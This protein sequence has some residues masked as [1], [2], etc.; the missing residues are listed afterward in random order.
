MTMS[1]SSSSTMTPPVKGSAHD[2]SPGG[3]TV[4]GHKK[5]MDNMVTSS[6]MDSYGSMGDTTTTAETLTLTTSMGNATTTAQSTW[7]PASSMGETTTTAQTTWTPAASVDYSTTTAQTTWIPATSMGDSTT[8]A[9][10]TWTPAASIDYSTASQTTW[11]S[12]AS[13]DGMTTTAQTTWTPAT[14]WSAMNT[15]STPEYGSGSYGGGAV[16]SGYQSCMQGE[17]FT[18]LSLCLRLTPLLSVCCV[19]WCSYDGIL[20]VVF[21]SRHINCSGWFWWYDTHCY[22]RSYAGHL[23]LRSFRH[24]RICW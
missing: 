3:H 23:A 8:T 10:S 12:S 20:N 22:C 19:L 16:G 15:Y 13:M 4:E 7:T 5:G 17:I 14:T 24:Q 9:Q 11:T 1:A 21:S 6:G 18:N 2:G